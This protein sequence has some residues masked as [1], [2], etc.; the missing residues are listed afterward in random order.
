MAQRRRLCF[1]T[2]F[3]ATRTPLDSVI[4][5]EEEAVNWN[6]R[7]VKR[8]SP[9][10]ITRPWA[11]LVGC[12]AIGL[13]SDATVRAEQGWQPKTTWVFAVGVLEWQ[14]P[15]SWPNMPNAKLNRRDVELVQYFRTAGVPDSQ[16]VYLQDR[17]ATRAKIQQ[18]LT[19]LLSLSRPGDLLVFYYAGHG[20]RDR[21]THAV[22]FANYDAT[23]GA[24]AWS[25]HSIVDDVEQGFRGERAML[26]ADCC[27]SGG[28][29]DEVLNRKTHRVHYAYLCSAFSHNSS[30]RNWTFTESL[31]QGFRGHPAVDLDGNGEIEFAELGRFAELDMGFI[32]RQKAVFGMTSDFQKP[33]TVSKSKGPHPPRLG[34]RI[35]V[36]WQGKWYRAQVVDAAEHRFKVHYVK[37]ADSWDEWIGPDRMRPFQPSHLSLD[38][39]VEV[40]WPRDQKWYP[41]KIRRTWYGLHFVHYDGYPDEWDEWVASDAIRLK[42]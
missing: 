18:S 33:M 35:E 3:T 25:V 20:A 5:T 16:I 32:E 26:L 24:S 1:E 30:T 41:S 9:N 14:K 22:H 38:A 7:V 12:L 34:D 11:A 23:D 4:G 27:F 36:E 17:E 8:L 31:L 42:Q 37:Y 29:A 15:E 13:W 19:H 28:L 10:S 39:Q 40:R 2:T 6:H 21:K